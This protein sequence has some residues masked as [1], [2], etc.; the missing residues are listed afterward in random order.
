MANKYAPVVPDPEL[1]L[2]PRRQHLVKWNCRRCKKTGMV[3]QLFDKTTAPI[4]AGIVRGHE[5][6][7]SCHEAHGMRHVWVD[8]A[9][10]SVSFDAFK[11]AS[12][13]TTLERFPTPETV[14]APEA[15]GQR[16]S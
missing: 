8:H 2:A 16:R 15:H 5:R 7:S 3:A 14:H 10:K 4:A 9:G 12:G 6:A 1:D 13:A 11:L